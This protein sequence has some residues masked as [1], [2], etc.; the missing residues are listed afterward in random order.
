MSTLIFILL[1]VI[2]VCMTKISQIEEFLLVVCHLVKN[3]DK[4]VETP[5]N[6]HD[7]LSA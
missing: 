7:E 6:A 4:N 3:M 1:V 5:L 2:L